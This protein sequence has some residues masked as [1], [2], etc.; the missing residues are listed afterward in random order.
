VL[1][2]KDMI[3]NRQGVLL[4]FEIP[5]SL[6]PYMLPPERINSEDSNNGVD[7][8]WTKIVIH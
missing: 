6:N 8:V 7:S 5:S 1:L 2:I 4:F 3:A